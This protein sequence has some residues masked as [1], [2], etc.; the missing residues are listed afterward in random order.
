M[1]L[2]AT[3]LYAFPIGLCLLLA[4]AIR[5][6]GAVGLI[7]GYDGDLSPERE[8]ALARDTALVLVAAAAGVGVLAID[9]RTDAVPRPDLLTTLAVVVPTA[10][11]LWKW[12]VREPRST[13]R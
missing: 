4:W 3:L 12:N 7:A 13:S 9:S 8:A 5:Y 11:L 6:R 10:W 1:A 2:A